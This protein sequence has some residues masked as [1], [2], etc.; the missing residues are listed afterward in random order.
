M[1]TLLFLLLSISLLGCNTAPEKSTKEA[2]ETITVSIRPQKYLVEQIAGDQ[3]NINVL[4]ADGSGPETYE[5][6]AKQMKEVSESKTYF[7]TGLLDFEK[8]WLQKV[9]ELHPDLKIVNTAS[10][11][12]LIEG[13]MHHD[14]SHG[15]KHH[16]HDAGVDPH[17]WLSI[18]E[19]KVQ[20]NTILKELIRLK[21]EMETE[22]TGKHAALNNRLDSLDIVIANKFRSLGRQ[23]VFMIYHP[24]LSYFS[25]DYGVIQLPIELGGKE[26]SPAYMKELIDLAKENQIN[27]IFYSEQ[28]DKKS[29]QTLSDQLSLELVPFNPLEEN[30]EQNLLTFTDRIISS[31]VK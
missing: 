28:F 29:A 5:P 17:I 19:L 20:S 25:R 16:H 26:P 21:P 1:R 13:E 2:K 27:T 30:V 31:A 11:V 3:F 18:R 6:S 15:E 14:H 7:M 12:D 10:G 23:P 8:G 22:F 24:A 9:A 4:V